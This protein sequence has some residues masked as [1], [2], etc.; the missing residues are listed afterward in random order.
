LVL[1]VHADG[2]GVVKVIRWLPKVALVDELAEGDTG[3]GGDAVEPD[4][5]LAVVA[6]PVVVVGDASCSDALPIA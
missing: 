4:V 3:D 1:A 2:D 6:L 5:T